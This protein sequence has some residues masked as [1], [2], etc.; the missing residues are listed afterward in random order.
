[1]FSLENV[2][3]SHGLLSNIAGWSWMGY[4]L[5]CYQGSTLQLGRVSLAQSDC[6]DLVHAICISRQAQNLQK[7]VSGDPRVRKDKGTPVS[8]SE[9]SGI[10]RCW[11]SDTMRLAVLSFRS[12]CSVFQ[13]MIFGIHHRSKHTGVI[14]AIKISVLR[15]G[16]ALKAQGIED[17]PHPLP[18]SNGIMLHS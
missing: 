5:R 8:L 13:G 16:H 3:R 14:S 9:D 2:L 7:S 15:K 17:I 10:P 12:F 18:Q 6:L 4:L 1:M 11:T